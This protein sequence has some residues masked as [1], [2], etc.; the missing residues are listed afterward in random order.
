MIPTTKG[1]RFIKGLRLE[2]GLTAEQEG[3]C[4]GRAMGMSPQEA[5]TAMGGTCKISTVKGWERNNQHVRAR[6]AD[7]S[8]MASK[9]AILKTGLDREWIIGRLMS[10]VDRCMQAE[11]VMVKGEPTGEFSFDSSGANQALRMLGDTLG[12]FKP[13]EVQPGDEYA[14]LSDDDIA[15]ITAELAAQTGLIEF[16]QGVK[17]APGAQQV[18]EVQA[19]LKAT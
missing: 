5:L 7:L 17:A 15:R 19:V 1:K 2:T 14:N 12:L 4:R 6:I 13:A 16:A 9:N 8:A 10:V 3:F 18:I 11:P